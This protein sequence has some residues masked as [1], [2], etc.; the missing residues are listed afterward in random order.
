MGS[1]T[2]RQIETGIRL[3]TYPGTGKQKYE[4][5]FWDAR[6]SRYVSKAF[7]NIK[8]ARS[9]RAKM[10]LGSEGL[11]APT[12][13]LDDY[14]QDVIDRMHHGLIRRA[15]GEEYRDVTVDG[16]RISIDH[17]VSPRIGLVP[18]AK[19]R[20]EDVQGVVNEMMVA[21]ASGSTIRNALTAI[22]VVLRQA[23][24]EGLMAANP[25]RDVSA[26]S[27]GR[28][29]DAAVDPDLVPA[30]IDAVPPRLRVAWGLGFYG[31]LRI[32]EILGLLQEDV[33][34][35]GTIRVCRQRL[36]E[37]GNVLA[38]VKTSAGNRIVPVIGPLAEL[39]EQYPSGHE[40]VVKPLD[41]TWFR[42][43]SD[44]GFAAA[45]LPRITAHQARH[46]YA[47]MMI[48]AGTDVKALSVVLGHRSISTTLDVYGHLYPRSYDTMR[49]NL[50]RLLRGDATGMGG[51]NPA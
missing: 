48:A 4:A 10:E 46:T 24:R 35:D 38:P 43:L 5:R 27:R 25:A 17:H 42:R 3:H 21:G 14:A 28:R 19:L 33:R 16:Y 26:P 2:T 29:V 39:L 11:A 15:S 8:A 41:R 12:W 31:G 22:G 49:A 34:P 20:H 51:S 23:R 37:A 9:W 13:R 47:S 44:D 1:R 30:Y 32:G 45:G 18:L 36:H 6:S 50:E 40:H 7:S